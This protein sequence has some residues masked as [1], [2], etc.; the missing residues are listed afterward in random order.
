MFQASVFGFHDE[1]SNRI[2][3]HLSAPSFDARAL[4]QICSEESDQDFRNVLASREFADAKL[5][6]FLFHV[7]HIMVSFIKN[8]NW[9]GQDFLHDG[10]KR[11]LKKLVGKN[12]CPD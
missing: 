11:C 5:L 8:F 9:D 4:K 6:L 12:L 2:F 10:Q 7:C 3:L 1:R